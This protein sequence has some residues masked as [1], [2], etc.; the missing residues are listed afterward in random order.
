MFSRELRRVKH[1]IVCESQFCENRKN[2]YL[3]LRK[4]NF[5]ILTSSKKNVKDLIWNEQKCTNPTTSL[6]KK[7]FSFI[8]YYV[9]KAASSHRPGGI[10]MSE[11]SIKIWEHIVLVERMCRERLLVKQFRVMHLVRIPLQ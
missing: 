3:L 10:H 8:Y 1:S 7:T 2:E 9:P 6:L 4:E 5:Y 11:Y